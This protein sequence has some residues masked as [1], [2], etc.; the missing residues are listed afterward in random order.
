MNS[1]T[2][3]KKGNADA[4]FYQEIGLKKTQNKKLGNKKIYLKNSPFPETLEKK[5]Q[6]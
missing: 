5:I 4:S 1:L 2:F 3:S 6:R